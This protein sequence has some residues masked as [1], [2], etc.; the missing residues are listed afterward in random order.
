M[1]K[2]EGSLEDGSVFY[3]STDHNEHLKIIIGEG[4]VIEG[5]DIGIKAMK[6]GEKA[7]IVIKSKYGYG[8]IG[9]P[10]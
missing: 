10:P 8:D 5:L 4:N 1:V 2:Y 6:L 7:D 9:N 3:R